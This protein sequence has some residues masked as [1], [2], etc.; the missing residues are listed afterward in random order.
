M[1]E[2]ERNTKT[3]LVILLVTNIFI[4]GCKAQEKKE[5]KP[6]I[7]ND[8]FKY[9]VRGYAYVK[10]EL[11]D[12]ALEEFKK[13]S[14]LGSLNP[15]VYFFIGYIYSCKSMV[16]ESIPYLKKAIEIKPDFGE[17]YLFLGESYATKGLLEEAASCL[18]KVVKVDPG[19]N[20]PPLLGLAY[21][22]LAEEYQDRKMLDQAI[23]AYK[24]AI[25]LN[26][27]DYKVYVNLGIAY[28]DK[29]L[30]EESI[31]SYEKAIKI[32]PHDPVAYNNLGN[33][34]MEYATFI[35]STEKE[36][37]KEK[38]S[39]LE[40]RGIENFEKVI[41]LAPDSDAAKMARDSLRIIEERFIEAVGEIYKK[42]ISK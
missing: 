19:F 26:P 17:A 31:S 16:D 15:K 34:C 40:N 38:V 20:N 21:F 35:V 11:Y 1:G 27:D 22:R 13:A 3:I 25:E 2:K 23:S 28:F 42:N 4:A 41:R 7:T 30:F 10:D 5:A 8:A 36:F 14:Q 6:P 37:S 12:Q 24:K 39:A 29:R 9:E 33:S 32:N 18:E